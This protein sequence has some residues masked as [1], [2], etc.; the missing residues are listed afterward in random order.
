M[1]DDH[2]RLSSWNSASRCPFL[3]LI[4]RDVQNTFYWVEID[5]CFCIVE[6]EQAPRQVG[7]RCYRVSLALPEHAEKQRRAERKEQPCPQDHGG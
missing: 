5:R 6:E 3:A 7:E 2:R 1:L 4:V